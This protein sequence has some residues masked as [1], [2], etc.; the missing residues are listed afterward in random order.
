VRG[1]SV[2]SLA[3]VD[4][5]RAEVLGRR[6]IGV[7]LR[8]GTWTVLF[9]DVV[10]STDQRVRLGDAAVDQLQREHDAVVAGVLAAYGGELVKST[11]DGAE[12]AFAGASDALAAAVAI[13][14]R[15][16]RRIGMPLSRFVCAWG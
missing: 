13:Q 1:P 14:Q 15:L 12:C 7:A 4:S 5:R 6:L 16:E 10:G 9:T 2:G 8:A 3:G 11:G